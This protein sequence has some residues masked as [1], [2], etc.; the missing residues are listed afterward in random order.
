[1]RH[2]G[3]FI[4]AALFCAPAAAEEETTVS[5]KVKVTVEIEDLIALSDLPEAADTAVKAG[6]D[7]EEIAE[8]YK[9][10]KKDKVKGRAAVAITK[11][12][13][14]E[15]KEGKS[16]KGMSGAVHACMDEGHKGTAL[17]DCFK[18]EWEKKPHKDK[19]EGKEEPPGH[20]KHEDKAKGP[21]K[22]KAKGPDKDKGKGAE[23]A[24]EKAKGPDKKIYGGK[25]KGPD[26]EKGKGGGKGKGKG[27]GPK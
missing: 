11:H 16:N 8:T 10:L 23:K 25:G 21:D 20:E 5:V 12:F 17:V 19:H 6:G 24:K 9:K 26:K 7:E 1:M 2:A 3:A 27:K 13:E 18:A 22:D 14:K 15:A 4:A